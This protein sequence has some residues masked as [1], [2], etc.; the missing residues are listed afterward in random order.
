MGRLTPEDAS[1][2]LRARRN[3]AHGLAMLL[4][5]DSF[6]DVP[7]EPIWRRHH[8]HAVELL[9]DNQWRVVEVSRGMGVAEAWSALDQLGNAA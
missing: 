2:L 4:D 7:A 9:R 1:A 8:E 5:V 3:R 6:A